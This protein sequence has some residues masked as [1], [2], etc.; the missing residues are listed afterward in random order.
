MRLGCDFVDRINSVLSFHTL[1]L[2]LF[3]CILFVYDTCCTIADSMNVNNRHVGGLMWI[4]LIYAR[5]V[6]NVVLFTVSTQFCNSATC[7]VRRPKNAALLVTVAFGN[8][9][10]K[11]I[12]FHG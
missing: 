7:E 8:D 11:I 5:A 1:T 4:I 3:Y 6:F 9:G 10:T 2:V 12:Y